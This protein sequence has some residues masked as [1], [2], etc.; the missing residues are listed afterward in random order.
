M[1]QVFS[2]PVGKSTVAS[3]APK[4]IF[5]VVRVTEVIPQGKDLQELF[6]RTPIQMES[7]QLG[8]MENQP[9]FADWYDQLEREMQ[10]QWAQEETK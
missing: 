5:Y 3:N 1:R 2:T 8:F 10:V 4:S 7:R 6:A 9:I